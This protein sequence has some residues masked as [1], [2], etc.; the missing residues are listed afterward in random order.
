MKQDFWTSW[1][2]EYLYELNVRKTWHTGS[3]IDIRIGDIVIITENNVPNVSW[4]VGRSMSIQPGKHDV[5]R[6]ATVKIRTGEYKRIIKKLCPLPI[7][8]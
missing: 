1:H 4:N 3:T 5:V 7:E 6:V 8:V 2:E